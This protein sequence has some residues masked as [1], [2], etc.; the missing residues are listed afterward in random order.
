MKNPIIS[1]LR[2]IRDAHAKKFNYNVEAI[3]RDW[4]TLEPW[5]EKRTVTLR[6]GRIV[7][8]FPVRK[9]ARVA[10]PKCK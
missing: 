10:K 3:L 2:R 7:P 6:G 5:Q 4:M 8:A 9:R 1:E